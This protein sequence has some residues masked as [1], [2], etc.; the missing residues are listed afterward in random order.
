MSNVQ[1]GN[2]TTCST[3]DFNLKFACEKNTDV[4]GWSKSPITQLV[5]GDKSANHANLPRPTIADEL[6]S[7]GT[8]MVESCL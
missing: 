1:R 4:C 5:G 7:V 2:S 8:C 3:A 6:K